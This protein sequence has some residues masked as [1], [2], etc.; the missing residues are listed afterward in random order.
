ML[1]S[2]PNKSAYIDFLIRK[3]L[4]NKMYHLDLKEDEKNE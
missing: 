1:D 4:A 3:D 2:N